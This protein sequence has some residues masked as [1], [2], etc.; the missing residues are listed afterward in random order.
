MFRT[1]LATG[2]AAVA[3]TTALATAAPAPLLAQD[4]ASLSAPQIEF[5]EWT[6]DNGLRVIAI[7]DDSTGQ[8]TTS[9]WYEVG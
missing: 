6:L 9:L 8:V 4:T 5:T 7:P 1:I 2:A 3:L